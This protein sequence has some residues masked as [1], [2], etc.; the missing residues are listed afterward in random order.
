M[1]KVI[2]IIL[3]AIIFVFSFNQ[4]VKYKAAIDE[5]QTDIYAAEE[6]YQSL[7]SKIQNYTG[8]TK[9]IQQSI[10]N[11]NASFKSE[12]E[13]L[14]NEYDLYSGYK[15]K[16]I[17]QYENYVFTWVYIMIFSFWFLFMLCPPVRWAVYML[18]TVATLGAVAKM[19]NKN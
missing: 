4:A 3:L 19:I 9:E 10:I 17:N 12:M 6:Q 16:V 18:L 11:S 15:D 2:V 8:D 13:S 1:K 7:K 5:R 14:K